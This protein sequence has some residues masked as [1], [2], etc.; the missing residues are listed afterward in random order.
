V[1]SIEVEVK[2]RIHDRAGLGTRLEALGARL[3]HPRELEDN[4]L[5]DFPD[6][7]LLEKGSILRIR[8]LDRAAIVTFKS[9]AGETLGAK[10]RHEIESAF[11]A[12]EAGSLTA[13]I[14]ALGLEPVFR[15][16]KYRTTW[17]V[18]GLL[19]MLDETPIGDF[20][21]LEGDPPV[22]ASFAARLGYRPGDFITGSYRELYLAS[23]AGQSGSVDRMVFP[24]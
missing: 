12:S 2:I 8:I 15:Y 11:P 13:I 16:Q 1:S 17:E 4:H 19:I 22:I 6:R 20:M 18:P 24:T 23:P 14:R 21:E 5:Y 9:R 10:V 3:L 7:H